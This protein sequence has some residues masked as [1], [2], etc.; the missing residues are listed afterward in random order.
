MS[1]SNS[2]LAGLAALVLVGA[3]SCGPDQAKAR[4]GE[5]KESADVANLAA[6]AGEAKRFVKM[7]ANAKRFSKT[8]DHYTVSLIHG[9][10]SQN[11]N[12]IK[13]LF[14]GKDKL[15][16]SIESKGRFFDNEEFAATRVYDNADIKK[17]TDRPWGMTG[18]LV[19]HLPGN[20]DLRVTTMLTVNR[21]DRLSHL[22]PIRTT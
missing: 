22:K 8:R 20:V 3:I 6:A 12:F 4:T 18:A 9:Q 21:E 10:V 16:I 1:F 13:S 7:T 11:D 2:L 17:Q 14:S 5:G 19:P 15:I